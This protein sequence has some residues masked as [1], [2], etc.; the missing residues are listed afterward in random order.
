MAGAGDGGSNGGFPIPTDCDCD[1]CFQDMLKLGADIYLAGGDQPFEDAEEAMNDYATLLLPC[2][3]LRTTSTITSTPW[4]C[5]PWLSDPPVGVPGTQGVYICTYSRTGARTQTKK[6]IRRCWD[7]VRCTWTETRTQ[8]GTQTLANY[9]KVI[10]PSV[11]ACPNPPAGAP[12]CTPTPDSSGPW[13]PGAGTPC[14]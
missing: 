2:C 11:P 1:A 13:L 10:P 8:R 12:A 3:R 5:G 14:C 7:C 4:T 6:S 9:I